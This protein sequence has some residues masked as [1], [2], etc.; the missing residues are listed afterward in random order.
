MSGK[1]NIKQTTNNALKAFQD[2]DIIFITIPYFTMKKA[3]RMV[4]PFVH[5]NLKIVVMVEEK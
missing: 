4:T 2:A 1:G 5:P 3:A